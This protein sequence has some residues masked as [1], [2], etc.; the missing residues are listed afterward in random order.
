MGFGIDQARTALAATYG[1]DWDVQAAAEALM[2]AQDYEQRSSQSRSD[3]NLAKEEAEKARRHAERRRP[4][5]SRAETPPSGAMT[6]TAT[7]GNGEP[8]LLAQASEIGLNVFK[9]ASSYWQTGRKA[10]QKAV[11][12]RMTATPSPGPEPSG[13]RRPKWMTSEVGDEVEAPVPVPAQ[14]RPSPRVAEETRSPPS[15]FKDSDDEG[16]APPPPLSRPSPSARP[17]PVEAPR[18]PP[19][20]R[21]SAHRVKAD[22]PA[23]S[24]VSPHRRLNRPPPQKKPVPARPVA[25]PRRI[26][27]ATPSQIATAEQHRLKGNDLFKLGR[28]ADAST[29]YTSALD[30]LPPRHLSRVPLLTNRAQASLHNGEPKPAIED[31][32]TA[33]LFLG[34]LHALT[35]QSELESAGKALGRRAK[36]YEAAEKWSSALDDWTLSQRS[37]GDVVRGAG[38]IKVIAEGV[39]RCKRMVGG[40]ATNGETVSKAKP[41]AR[42][43][44]QRSVQGSGAAVKALK[45]ANDA[46]DAEDAQRLALKD[47]V[48]ARL[49]S[50]KGGKETN[51]RALIASLDS[52]L[53]DGFGWQKVGLHELVTENQVK[54]RYVKAI[55]RL[56][57]DKVRLLLFPVMSG[58]RLVRS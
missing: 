6:A 29:S 12:E 2:G 53:W 8:D 3:A 39:T 48:D 51:L 41:R 35:V 25:P 27:T 7:T 4:T 28:Y 17:P 36:A 38:G 32:T 45:A 57:P 26:I 19:P 21:Q 9:S 34:A 43:V 14:S 20:P 40:P 10:V 58:L 56:H 5:K 31:C 33:L 24:Y 37:G 47:T 54:I 23:Q 50:W 13:S 30:V 1:A 18:R 44:V 22:A 42:P 49:A 46:A 11:E 16:E 52:V 15:L 55:A